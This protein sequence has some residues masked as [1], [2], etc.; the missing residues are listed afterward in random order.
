MT[1]KHNLYQAMQ[2]ICAEEFKDMTPAGREEWFNELEFDVRLACRNLL[3][4]LRIDV[5]NDP[6]MKDAPEVMAERLLKSMDGRL[7]SFALDVEQLP[8]IEF[9]PKVV[10]A[11]DVHSAAIMPPMKV[12]TAQSRRMMT[13]GPVV[14]T[15]LD[16]KDLQQRKYE[17]S[18]CLD[19][20]VSSR[21]F[22]AET[23]ASFFDWVFARPAS[24][25]TYVE[26][27]RNELMQAL[28]DTRHMGRGPSGLGIYAET[29][30]L[31][32]KRMVAVSRTGTLENQDKWLEFMLTLRK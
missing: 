9:Q 17:V 13:Y 3:L 7:H 28:E 12:E 16:I 1:R 2:N 29:T 31:E 30:S 22:S 14:C 26:I 11:V 15:G 27:I 32:G 4:A 21:T 18:I 23:L 20:Q 19:L 5:D 25:N 6:N 10:S 8:K 24:L